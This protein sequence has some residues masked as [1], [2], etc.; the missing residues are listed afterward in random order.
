M[1]LR[2]GWFRIGAKRT[3]NTQLV[4][5][6][7]AVNRFFVYLL[8]LLAISPALS[9]AERDSCPGGEWQTWGDQGDGTYWNPVL[10]SDRI[11]IYSF[12]S[13]SD[14]GYVDVDYLHHTYAG[15]RDSIRKSD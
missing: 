11:G 2:R 12:N 13:R 8:F 14:D 5:P 10:P 3:P 15:P 1:S 9:A 6:A 4:P 7:E